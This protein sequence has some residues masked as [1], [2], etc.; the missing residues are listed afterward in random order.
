[1]RKRTMSRIISNLILICAIG[2]FLFSGY[3]LYGI[4]SEYKKGSSEYD[5]LREQVIV[6]EIP[7]VEEGFQKE[8]TFNVDFETLQG[9]NKDVVGWIRFDEPVNISYPIVKGIDNEKYLHTTFEGK[10]NSAGTLFVD[11]HNSEDFEDKNTFIYGHNMKNGT[12][13][14]MLKKYKNESFCRENPYFYIYTPDKKICTYQI[15]SV[16]VVDDASEIY[17]RVFSGEEEFLQYIEMARKSALY[18]VDV[19]VGAD[20]QIVSLSTCTNVNENE[21]LLVQGVKVKE[22]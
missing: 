19:A 20:S 4:F 8:A 2:V 5:A 22:E 21:R 12:M 11:Y 1:M 16:S 18:Q 14:G 15:F 17:K 3:K 10:R 7:K 9:I 6:Q 13:F